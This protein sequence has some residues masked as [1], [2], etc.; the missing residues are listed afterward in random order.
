MASTES[1]VTAVAEET[2]QFDDAD[3][4]GEEK[5]LFFFAIHCIMTIEIAVNN[6]LFFST[7]VWV[8]N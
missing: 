7:Q 5:H 3:L 6:F 1:G 4:R 2:L 8:I